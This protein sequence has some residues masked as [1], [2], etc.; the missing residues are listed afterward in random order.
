MKNNQEKNVVKKVWND[1]KESTRNFHEINKENL[2]A[3]HADDVQNFK[4]ATK[5]DPNFQEFKETK[6]LKDKARVVI[7]HIKEG[8][9]LNSEKEA[10]KREEIKSHR[11]HEAMLEQQ[12]LNHQN[13][14]N[15]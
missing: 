10:Q 4:N 13:S 9:K 8:A 5:P 2:K 1:L 12:R 11:N 15:R 6:G 3:V 7:K 14:I